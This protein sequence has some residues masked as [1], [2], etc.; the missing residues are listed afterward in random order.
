MSRFKLPFLNE[1]F[2]VDALSSFLFV[3]FNSS[4]RSLFRHRRRYACILVLFP[5]NAG[6]DPASVGFNEMERDKGVDI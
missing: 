1:A 2:H 4:P 3:Q 5:F 6:F